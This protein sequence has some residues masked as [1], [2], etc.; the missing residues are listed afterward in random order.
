MAYDLRFEPWLPFR[1]ISGA[2]EWLPPYA[3][4]DR[5]DDDPIVAL[6]C[7]RPDFDGAVTEFL[8]GL[9]SIALAPAEE[10]DWAKLWRDPPKPE[11]LRKAL[12]KLP[13]AFALDGDGPR[14]FQDYSHDDLSESKYVNP[15]DKLLLGHPGDKTCKENRDHFQKRDRVAA[16]GRPAAAMALLSLQ[17]YA[18]GGGT[19]HNGSIRG[20]GPLSTLADPRGSRGSDGRFIQ[21]LWHLI[22][23]NAETVSQFDDRDGNNENECGQVDIFPWLGPTRISQGVERPGAAK[24]KSNPSRK[25]RVFQSVGVLTFERDAD[26][27]QSYFS[28]PRRVRLDFTTD[29]GPCGLTGMY[30]EVLIKSV[31]MRA[32]GA[33]Y[34][35]WRHPLSPRRSDQTRGGT[36][37]W[38]GGRNAAWSDW[39]GM[40]CDT[41]SSKTTPAQCIATFKRRSRSLGIREFRILAFGFKFEDNKAISWSQS[42]LPGFDSE[43]MSPVFDF[44]AKATNGAEEAAKILARQVNF[45]LVGPDRSM[46]SKGAMTDPL[47]WDSVKH[48]LWAN[49][50]AVFFQIIGEIAEEKGADGPELRDR[51]RRHLR[52]AALAIFDL[53]CPLDELATGN[54]RRPIAARHS[55]VMALEGYGKAG[56]SLFKALGLVVPEAGKTKKGKAA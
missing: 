50:Q 7:P 43:I 2:V 26:P 35:G 49:T 48:S 12:A 29:R 25:K 56:A 47:L 27:R 18:C 11:A 54:M 13:D 39:L 8:I 36:K 51:F 52:D 55:L 21:S 53:A 38:Q 5:I 22:W 37:A 31:R 19:G 15:L 14:A 44:A 20:P 33:S 6:A 46:K 30:E 23:A 10:A 42:A 40:L 32:Y 9:F 45:G 34:Q 24:G 41:A 4:T 16:L 3:V 1:R 17:T 28:T